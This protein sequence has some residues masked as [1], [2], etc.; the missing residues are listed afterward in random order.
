MSGKRES[1][2]ERKTRALLRAHLNLEKE[3]IEEEI[4]AARRETEDKKSITLLG[5]YCNSPNTRR[6]V[7]TYDPNYPIVRNIQ[8]PEIHTRRMKSQSKYA[9]QEG[10]VTDEVG[11][12]TK[13]LTFFNSHFLYSQEKNLDF[14]RR[15]VNEKG[16]EQIV[17]NILREIPV[18][19]D[20]RDPQTFLVCR[21]ST[22]GQLK[23]RGE[24]ANSLLK[25]VNHRSLLW[26]TP[27]LRICFFSGISYTAWV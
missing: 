26:I 3:R 16:F 8:Q 14:G 1:I 22:D 13:C 10:R 19:T 18:T 4:D 15:I 17:L 2:D 9:T 21:L 6:G 7:E 25:Q 11:K 20:T 24:R 23:S 12:S 27:P 5:I